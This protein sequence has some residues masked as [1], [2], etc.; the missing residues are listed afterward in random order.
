MKTNLKGIVGTMAIGLSVMLSGCATT[1]LASI[2]DI[3]KRILTPVGQDPSGGGIRSA[4]GQSGTSIVA[5]P[6]AGALR[7]NLSTDGSAPEWPKVIVTDLSFPNDQLNMS[8]GF[9]LKAND[10]ITFNAV[11]W[12]SEKTKEQFNNLSLCAPELPK[13]SNNFVTTW[14]TF[15]IS[16]KTTGQLRT[17]GPKPPYSKLPGGPR[18]NQWM[19]SPFGLYYVG[20][21]LTIVGY[22]DS[23]S[24]DNR[25]FW[26]K[27]LKGE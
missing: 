22:D 16:G 10:C 4:L 13:Q 8:R 25:R 18:M 7:H 20:S 17:D 3:G 2:G 6:L 5:S 9:Q 19:T 23:F 11:L 1:D 24:V 26:I 21:I 14:R 12:R 15:P 27:N